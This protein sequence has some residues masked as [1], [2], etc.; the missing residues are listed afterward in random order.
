MPSIPGFGR[1]LGEG[2]GNPLQCSCLESATD[3]KSWQATVHWVAKIRHNWVHRHT[4][5]PYM[6]YSL[7]L[8]K[9]QTFFYIIIYS[10]LRNSIDRRAWKGTVPE[11]TRE[12]RHDLVTKQYP[13]WGNNKQNISSQSFS[14]QLQ[15]IKKKRYLLYMT[16]YSHL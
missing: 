13:Y 14:Q 2:K 15:I 6:I 16:D 7:Y 8:S 9:T 11:V 12:S 3:R 10:C 4:Y 1:S 5:T